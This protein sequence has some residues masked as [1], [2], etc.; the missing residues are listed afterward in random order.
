MASKAVDSLHMEDL[1]EPQAHEPEPFSTIPCP[2]CRKDNLIDA[3]VCDDCGASLEA[4]NRYKSKIGVVRDTTGTTF[5]TILTYLPA[6]CGLLAGIVGPAH[7]LALLG[8]GSLLVTHIDHNRLAAAGWPMGSFLRLRSFV[9]FLYLAHRSYE[10]GE[11]TT[12][13]S[14]WLLSMM[15]GLFL[16]FLFVVGSG[17]GSYLTALY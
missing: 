13:A 4:L 14:H 2:N 1:A 11:G 12:L 15:G 8:L 10:I 3:E 5:V 9:P 16:F 7:I 6:P 17:V